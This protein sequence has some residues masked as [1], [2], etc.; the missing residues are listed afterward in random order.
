VATREAIVARTLLI[1][2][3]ILVSPSALAEPVD[4]LDPTPR[5]VE[6]AFEVSP[7]DKPIQTDTIYTP[8]IRAWLEAGDR[9]GWMKVT[10]DS[11]D[12]ERILLA[13]DDPVAGSFSDFV[14]IFDAVTGE[15][16]SAAL[17]GTL[18]KELDWGLFRS[19][20]RTQIEADMATNRVGGVKKPRRWMGQQLF[21]YCGDEDGQR[22]TVVDASRYDAASGYVNAVGDLS[23]RFGDM[24]IHTFSPLGEAVFS[25]V[26]SQNVAASARP[27]P[28]SAGGAAV[29]AVGAVAQPDWA[30]TPAVSAGPPQAR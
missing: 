23:V 22:C 8:K 27:N 13:D 5:W 25:E 10:V 16:I 14:W 19:K 1:G 24:T 21:G 30:S 7:R 17:S 2:L 18:T 26:E 20:V 15:V 9:R 12:V 11:H 6:V 29:T 4:L 28:H 3:L